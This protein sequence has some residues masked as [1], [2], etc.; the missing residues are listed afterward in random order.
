MSSPPAQCPYEK[1]GVRCT[2]EL[3]AKGRCRFHQ[4]GDLPALGAEDAS[5]D[6]ARLANEGNGNW[7]GFRIP[8]GTRLEGLCI[9][10]KIDLRDAEVHG[11]KLD[12]VHVTDDWIMN[13]AVFLGPL[14]IK[15]TEF[16][17]SFSAVDCRFQ[18]PV[19]L[20]GDY[21]KSALL[22]HCSFEARTVFSGTFHG[23]VSLEDSVFHESALFQGH[24]P[25]RFTTG[26]PAT[27]DDIVF[28]LFN[29]VVDLSSVDFRRPQRTRFV[30]VSLAKAKFSET[31]L[32]GVHFQ[33]VD[34]ATRG[35]ARMLYDEVATE[36]SKDEGYRALQ[37][38]RLEETYRN[39]RTAL[40]ESRD[41]A[42]ATDF[43]VREMETRR[44]TMPWWRREFFSVEALYLS[45]SRYGSSP[46]RALG[47]FL[48][49]VILHWLIQFHLV[50]EPT[51]LTA[52]ATLAETLQ[53]LTL[54]RVGPRPGHGLLPV[55]VDSAFRI[56]VA[57]QLAMLTLAMRGRIKRH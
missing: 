54:Q 52:Q 38:R 19:S 9:D 23:R 39:V 24:S 36:E 22:A 2:L 16:M 29:D 5:K 43:Y 8:A 31:D 50:G 12:R 26:S 20:R 48:A 47:W 44:R 6:L 32:R 7:A 46:S 34:W 57:A 41:Y 40:E 53:V 42:T 56:L 27:E 28:R 35:G 51:F 49:L 55:V 3:K 14:D 4:R 37:K 11:L 1:D 45:V 15:A 17:G 21:R 33:D 25:V 13:G 10:C 30:A 18:A